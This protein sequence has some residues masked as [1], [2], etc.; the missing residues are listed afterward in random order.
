MMIKFCEISYHSERKRNSVHSSA[1]WRRPKAQGSRAGRLVGVTS[2]TLPSADVDGMWMG[3][4]LASG[5]GGRGVAAT[6]E[7]RL[8]TATGQ[9]AATV[10]TPASP[11]KRLG[12]DRSTIR[13][14][15]F[16]WSPR[17]GRWIVDQALASAAG[18]GNARARPGIGPG[19]WRRFQDDTD[20]RV[21][22][23]TRPARRADESHQGGDLWNISS[24][25][26][27]ARNST[28]HRR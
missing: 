25:R 7:I 12:G 9:H 17:G 22:S 18:A 15:S 8:E 14:C 21:V 10:R 19:T 26:S 1:S 20:C 24:R 6:G 2:G 11:R 5:T 4:R 28:E 13:S 23:L 27:S 3:S 16:S